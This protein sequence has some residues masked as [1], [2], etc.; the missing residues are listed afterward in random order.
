[1]RGELFAHFTDAPETRGLLD[2]FKANSN[3]GNQASNQSISREAVS[4]AD[5][6]ARA[7]ALLDEERLGLD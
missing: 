4:A 1:M 6:C 7:S 2:F 5:L 3:L